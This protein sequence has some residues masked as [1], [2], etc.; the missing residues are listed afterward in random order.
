MSINNLNAEHRGQINL[1][2][3][4][5]RRQ[6]CCSFCR[7]IGHNLTTCNSPR[8]REFE[9]ICASQ[10]L[11][12]NTQEDFKN[13]LIEY[14]SSEELLI[15]TFAI[16]KFRVTTRESI[17]N[18]MD[19]ITNY[20]FRIYKNTNEDVEIIDHEN[21]FEDDLMAFIRELSSP[22]E[23]EIQ[24]NIRISEIRAMENLLMREIFI[25]TMTALI[26]R[27]AIDIDEYRKLKILSTINNNENENMNQLCECNICYDEKELKNFVKLGC[28]HEFCKDCIINTMKTNYITN[29]SCAFCRKEVKSIESR[30]NDVKNEINNYIE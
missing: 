23:G 9:V 12:T 21:Q 26:G 29:L 27:T 30:T 5:I 20:I 15:K 7:Q 25:V 4:S 10:V 8:L 13:W 2:P 1:F 11:Q 28:N 18:C 3:Q 24:E 19:L 6:Q 17:E 16:K 22:R 14:Y